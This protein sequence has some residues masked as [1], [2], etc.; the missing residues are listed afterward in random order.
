MLDVYKT[1]KTSIQAAGFSCRPRTGCDFDIGVICERVDNR[2]PRLSFWV[3]LRCGVWYLCCWSSR[4]WKLPPD[5]TIEEVCIGYLQCSEAC[6]GAPP[7]SMLDDFGLTEM[8]YDEFDV[9][10]GDQR[11]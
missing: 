10:L 9:I 3:V 11:N 7:P 1:L 6:F 5:V 8:D 4:F 2:L